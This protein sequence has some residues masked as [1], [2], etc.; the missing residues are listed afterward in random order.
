MHCCTFFGF[1][2][3]LVT[4]CPQV[5]QLFGAACLLLQIR[6][7]RSV[8]NCSNDLSREAVKSRRAHICVMI[9]PHVCYVH[10][11]VFGTK[12]AHT[13]TGPNSVG[14]AAGISAYP[15]QQ[16]APDDPPDPPEMPGINRAGLLN[17]RNKLRLNRPA[18]ISPP[19]NTQST[20]LS[21]PHSQPYSHGLPPDLPNRYDTAVSQGTLSEPYQTAPPQSSNAVSPVKTSAAAAR[22]ARRR[23]VAQEIGNPGTDA[24]MSPGDVRRGKNLGLQAHSQCCGFQFMNRVIFWCRNLILLDV[25]LTAHGPAW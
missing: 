19:T 7:R 4:A 24:N 18:L 11:M 3:W 8:A 13:S 2:Q 17:L 25:Q 6:P 16:A 20:P 22:L 21:Q 10:V 1:H 14:P 12:R 15:P 9:H 5:K 23:A